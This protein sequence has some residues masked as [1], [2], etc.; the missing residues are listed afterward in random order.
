[1]KYFLDTNIIIYAVK[2]KYPSI[3]EHFENI[4]SYNIFVPS[5]VKAEIDYGAKKSSNYE[6]TISI[7]NKFL[8]IYNVVPFTNDETFIYGNIRSDLEKNGKIIGGNDMLIAS[9]A[10]S[11]DG[12]LVTHNVEEFS[13]IKNL[14]IEDWTK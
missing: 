1:M 14:K 6:K 13:R 4:P 8:E 11:H 12:V 3:V 9:I 5:I 2:G 7:Y 10:L